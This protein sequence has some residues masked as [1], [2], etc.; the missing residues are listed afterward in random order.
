MSAKDKKK[1]TICIVLFFVIMLVGVASVMYPIANSMFF[2]PNL[3]PD[4][5]HFIKLTITWGLIWAVSFSVLG[6]VSVKIS[7]IAGILMF[8]AAGWN[9]LCSAGAYIAVFVLKLIPV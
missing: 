2:N 6:A 4:F 1:L 5:A 7:K 9:L 8:V 3:E